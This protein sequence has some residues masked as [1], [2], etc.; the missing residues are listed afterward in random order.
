VRSADYEAIKDTF[1]PGHADYTYWRK[2]GL[3]DWRGGGRSSARETAARVAAGAVAKN[4]FMLIL[5][6]PFAHFFQ[7]LVL[8][9]FL[10]RVSTLSIAIRFLHQI[11]KW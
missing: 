2:Y 8:S 3:R 1:R 6:L 7:P 11:K 9:I 4:G 5:A 10:L